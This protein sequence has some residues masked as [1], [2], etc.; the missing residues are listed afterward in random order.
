ML[1]EMMKQ[2]ITIKVVADM[3]MILGELDLNADTAVRQVLANYQIGTESTYLEEEIS[4]EDGFATE[5][6]SE[7]VSMHVA[8]QTAFLRGSS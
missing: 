2:G 4:H 3:E 1:G 8:N 5:S 7:I 6:I